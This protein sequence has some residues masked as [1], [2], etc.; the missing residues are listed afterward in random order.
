MN[1]TKPPAKTKVRKYVR[2]RGL[3]EFKIQKRTSSRL[4]STYIPLHA[5]TIGTDWFFSVYLLILTF[6]LELYA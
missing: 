1:T 5:F 4:R 3:L 2:N 6:F